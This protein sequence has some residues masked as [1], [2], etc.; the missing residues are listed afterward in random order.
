MV[1]KPSSNTPIIAWKFAEI[2]KQAGLPDGVFNLVIGPG[3]KVGNELVSN[4]D[5]AGIVFTGSREDWLPDGKRVWQYKA[6]AA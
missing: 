6:Q 4:K 1:A 3:D 2:F 5:V